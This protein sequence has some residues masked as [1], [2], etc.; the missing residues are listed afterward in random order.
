M[1]RI[2]V[3]GHVEW[4][5]QARSREPLQRGEIMHLYDTF[6]EPGG[7]GGVTARALP[8]LGAETSFF[9]ALGNDAAAAAAEQILLRDGCDLRAAR[10]TRRA[11]PSDGGSSTMRRCSTPWR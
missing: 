9:T 11:C 5:L 8:A 4:V 3:I 10:C 2:A 6:E 1:A 7:G